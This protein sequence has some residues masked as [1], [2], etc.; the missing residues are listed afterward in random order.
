MNDLHPV[1]Q[2]MAQAGGNVPMT[3]E[4]MALLP[5]GFNPTSVF[6]TKFQKKM[7]ANAIKKAKRAALKLKNKTKK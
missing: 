2:A 7:R 1:Q 3:S 6:P 5:K 4:Q